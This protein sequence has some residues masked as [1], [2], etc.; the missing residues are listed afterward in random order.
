MRPSRDAERNSMDCES[1][2][3]QLS[4]SLYGELEASDQLLLEA[5]LGHCS[6]CRSR[7]EKMI[8]GMRALDAWTPEAEARSDVQAD[9]AGV[10]VAPSTEKAQFW[11]QGRRSILVGLA[12]G[13]LLFSLLSFVGTRIEVEERGWALRFGSLP[14]PEE[15]R[16]EDGSG[17]PGFES[18]LLE[19][20][21]PQLLEILARAVDENG[22][23]SAELLSHQLSGWTRL[24]ELRDEERARAWARRS[25]V[26]LRDVE[27]LARSTLLESRANNRVAHQL[28]RGVM[29]EVLLTASP[30]DPNRPPSSD[31]GP[32]IGGRPR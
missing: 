21:E 22:R 29:G 17:S 24:Q 3:I 12:A 8:Y 16:G 2:R 4:A 26:G 13:L 11:G 30:P 32:S 23:R 9:V 20:L 19:Q 18:I 7:R 6:S 28:V 1:A 5:H 15:N 31:R 25:L 14:V 10:R 27:D